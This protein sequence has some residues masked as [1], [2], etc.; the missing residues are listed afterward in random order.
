MKERVRTGFALLFTVCLFLGFSH[1]PVVLALGIGLLGAVSAAEL[2]EPMGI[3]KWISAV[4]GL[5]VCLLV[6]Q[7]PALP[8]TILVGVLFVGYLLVGL[9]MM[10]ALPGKK[11]F[12][13]TEKVLILGA[14]PVFLACAWELRRGH[15]GL[16]MVILPIFICAA[17]DTFAYFIGRQFGKTPLAPAVSPKK[18]LEGAIGGGLLGVALVM[19][20]GVCLEWSG[21]AQ[22]RMVLLGAY[23][24]SASVVGQFG[25]L[26]LSAVKRV[27]GV[28]DFGQVLPGHG[29]I[30]DRIDSCL[31]VL[32]YTYLFIGCFGPMIG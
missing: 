27:A 3:R 31:L 26:C 20:L 22:I 19:V 11:T 29:G 5:A 28:K 30:L 2:A 13:K 14:V 1:V 23:A 18:T 24:L 16:A 9:E 10:V 32:P 6:C 15:A 25:D 8:M 7:W 21:L 12:R 4:V 17:T